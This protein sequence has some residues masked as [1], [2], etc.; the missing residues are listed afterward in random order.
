M[1]W[2]SG[3][4]CL[5]NFFMHITHSTVEV[6]LSEHLSFLVTVFYFDCYGT[7]VDSILGSRTLTPLT[8]LAPVKAGKGASAT[9]K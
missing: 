6:S 2:L 4:S 7:E 9:G 1:C 8:N 3:L 5:H